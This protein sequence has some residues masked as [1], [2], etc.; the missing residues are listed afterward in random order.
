LKKASKGSS[1]A[2]QGSSLSAGTGTKSKTNN[3]KDLKSWIALHGKDQK[4]QEDV[5][6]LGGKLGIKCSNSFQALSGGKYKV[7]KKGREER[8]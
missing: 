8:K 3:S 2:K 7:G 4:V 5:E 6:D 1:V